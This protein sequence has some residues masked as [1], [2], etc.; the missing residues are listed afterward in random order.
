LAA[1]VISFI[2]LKGGVAKTTTTVG[3][4]QVLD[5]VFGKKTLVID[6]DPQTN[7]TA[8]LIGEENWF[9]LNRKGFT[10]RTLF[11]DAMSGARNFNLSE[12]L[13]K[14]VGAVE[15]VKKVDLLPS[16]LQLLDIQDH[17]ATMRP[18]PGQPAGPAK[19][20]REGIK[21]ILDDY[22]YALID[23]PPSL[24]FITLNGLFISRGYVIPVIPDVLSTFGI[25]QIV[26]RISKFSAV[27]GKEIKPLGIV[28]TKV[29]GQAAIHKRTMEDMRK[30]TGRP[31][32]E[33][34]AGLPFPFV[35]AAC[36]PESAR[37]AEAAEYQK[38]NT[39]RQKWGYQQDGQYDAFVRFAEEFLIRC[40]EVL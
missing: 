22:D 16:S 29:R 21:G 30:K 34:G 9:E 32:D 14:S 6:L 17:L 10:I 39:V 24:G 8:M 31:M 2:N 40:G 35:F 11:E 25:P 1:K 7:A 15:E 26:A 37:M 3:L 27:A 28:A 38:I 36:F 4:A 13:Q 33:T 18:E 12:T 23:C 5:A 19:V 20:L